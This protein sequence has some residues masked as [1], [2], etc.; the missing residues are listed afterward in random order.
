MPWPVT[1]KSALNAGMNDYISK[2]VDPIL[3]AEKIE[4]WLNRI[5]PRNPER[6]TVDEKKVDEKKNEERQA[7][8]FNPEDV[9]DQPY[10]RQTAYRHR[11]SAPSLRTCRSQLDIL[12]ELVKQGRAQKG[13]TQAHKIKGASGYVAAG[14]F[15][16]TA[17]EMEQA[18]KAGDLK[19]P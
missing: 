11:P 15:Q 13:G 9:D 2:P 19:A 1:G 6:P 17:L 7:D 12:T 14:V 5:Q 18:G 16:K 10:G 4:K 8:T 3:L